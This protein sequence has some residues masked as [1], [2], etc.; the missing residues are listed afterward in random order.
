MECIHDIDN[1]DY[2]IKLYS[3]AVYTVDGLISKMTGQGVLHIPSM[4]P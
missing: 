2:A 1:H 4:L 3:T